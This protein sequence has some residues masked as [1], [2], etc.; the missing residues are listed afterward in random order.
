MQPLARRLLGDDPHLAA[1]ATQEAWVAYIEKP[2]QPGRPVQPWLGRV[3]RY[4]AHH[5]RRGDRR[6]AARERSHPVPTHAPPTH[7]VVARADLQDW[8]LGCVMEL[9]EPY[10]STI[11]QRFFDEQATTEMARQ[12]GVSEA[13]IRMRVQRALALLRVK[14]DSSAVAVTGSGEQEVF[15]S[16]SR[17]LSLA[18][19]VAHPSGPTPQFNMLTMIGAVM[20]A[21]HLLLASVLLLLL[22]GG[23][24]WGGV[25]PF[26]SGERS[27]EERSGP[28]ESVHGGAGAQET[29]GAGTKDPSPAG[30][31]DESGAGAPEAGED[32][33]TTA[34][35]PDAAASEDVNTGVGTLEVRVVHGPAGSEESPAIARVE[36]TRDVIPVVTHG[37]ADTGA[38][39]DCK[40]TGLPPG[41]YI[42]EAFL[43]TT[44]TRA[45]AKFGEAEETKQ[46]TI[47]FPGSRAVHGRLFGRRGGLD[48]DVRGD[49][50]ALGEEE[51]AVDL[52]PIS[53]DSA[54][55][56]S[57]LST[58][59][60]GTGE[61]RIDGVAPGEYLLRITS[62]FHVEKIAVTADSDLQH[63]IQLPDGEVSGRVLDSDSGEPA[64]WVQ[65]ILGLRASDRIEADL[66]R[67]AGLDVASDRLAP[68]ASGFYRFSHLPSGDYSILCNGS[69]HSPQRQSCTIHEAQPVVTL[70]FSLE[71][72][73]CIVLAIQ[74]E[75]GRDLES[76]R[77][78]LGGISWGFTGRVGGLS[79]GTHDVFGYAPGYEVQ[80]RP[81]V[82][83]E[84]GGATPVTFQ[85]A[86]AAETRL[87]FVDGAGKPL[88]DVRVGVPMGNYDV[89]EMCRTLMR[90]P[91][92]PATRTQEAGY[93]LLRGRVPGPCRVTAKKS[94]YAAF[95]GEITLDA[96][97]QE[98]R[99]TLTPADTKFEWRLRVTFVAEESEAAMIGIVA[100]DVLRSYG[101]V[102][103]SST[104]DLK[105]AITAARKRG[106]ETVEV[107]IES[108]AT[109]RA[110]VARVGTLGVRTEEFEVE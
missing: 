26:G 8:L 75:Q 79:P 59:V 5:M 94:G 35:V 15:D 30:T 7:E 38:D 34:S 47:R 103:L 102:A 105:G 81:G 93:V 95:D 50:L 64:K 70:D 73:T 24:W 80:L 13:A 28:R 20:S 10:R 58:H 32:S 97:V 66:L 83:F 101:G 31:F 3:V 29:A 107:V 27:T 1:D 71:P 68:D 16:R 14:I 36:V 43:G 82:A 88:S 52:L 69:N 9:R 53:G 76:P 63:D 108:G 67:R 90:D 48:V 85:L 45:R 17:L 91:Q 98:Q 44:W 2:P 41:G 49:Y 86:P 84:R 22:I 110:L 42:V 99:I 62:K 55:D 89:L 60:A 25:G 54:Q 74:D 40:F 19:I 56:E 109:T 11:L 46:V 12:E 18:A 100:D 37:I 96:A 65:V 51:L 92:T 6:R 104:D 72:G 106:D 57:V 61:Y 4:V 23:A 39:G 77:C 87:Y 78:W 21:K 33:A